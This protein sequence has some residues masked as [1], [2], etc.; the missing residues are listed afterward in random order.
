M[1]RG[2]GY[3]LMRPADFREEHVPRMLELY[4]LLCIERHSPMNPQLTEKFFL[5]LIRN[6][7]LELYGL[8]KCGRMDGIMGYFDFAGTMVTPIVG[9]DTSLPRS[10]GLYRMISSLALDI[11]LQNG[12][13]DHAGA[14]VGSFKR[15]RGYLPVM[16][17]SA[18]YV[19]HLPVLRRAAWESIRTIGERRAIPYIRRF[20][21]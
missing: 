18:V 4:N 2:T 11:A 5:N 16:E 3:E 1:L 7:P 21:L 9:Y 8:K 15:R 14:G 13:I 19:R 10:A 17:Y 6:R 20:Q 12:L